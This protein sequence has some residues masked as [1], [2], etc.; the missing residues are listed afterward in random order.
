M[1]WKNKGLNIFNTKYILAKPSTATDD[2]YINVESV[3]AHEY[4]HNW[5]GNRVTCRDWFQLSLKE[6]LTIFRDQSFSMDTTSH[7][8][9]RIGDVNALRTQQFPEDMS[10]LAHPVRPDS[11]IEINN[12]YTSTIYNKGAEVIRMMQTILGVKAFRKAMDLY[13]SRH[14]GQA[15]TIEDFAKAMED[16][17]GIDL[18]QFR[19]WYSQAGTPVLDITD[20]YDIDKKKIYLNDQTKLSPTP[21]QPTKLP[22][23]IPL[24]MG[25]LDVTGKE[26]SIPT[27]ILQIQKPIEVFEFE[28]IPAKPI[29]SLLRG[30][31]APVKINYD[32]SDGALQVLFK[33]DADQFNRWEAGQKYAI[34]TLLELIRDY[35]NGKHFCI[36]GRI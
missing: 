12:F 10:P 11:Y 3:I 28:N 18:Q 4:F 21:G 26:F 15:V 22:F 23:H 31:S 8:V 20:H 34:N 13:F 24:K 14:D 17:S 5:S 32:Y 19:L 36:S 25:L 1:L 29:P 30:F 33:H 9:A 7:T 16:A 2:D 35:Q 27:E 6:G